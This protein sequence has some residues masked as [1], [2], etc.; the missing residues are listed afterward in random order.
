MKFLK[1]YR[2][3]FVFLTLGALAGWVYWYLWGCSES[4][5]IKSNPLHSSLYGAVMGILLVNIF[6]K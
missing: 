5:P 3:Y 2:L 4:C 6:K 1:T